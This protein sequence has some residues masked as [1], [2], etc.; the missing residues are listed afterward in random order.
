MLRPCNAIG[1][2]IRVVLPHRVFT[3]LSCY[4]HNRQYVSLFI[5][6]GVLSCAAG[7]AVT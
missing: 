2:D 1:D 4:T 6:H 7:S 3:C 5:D